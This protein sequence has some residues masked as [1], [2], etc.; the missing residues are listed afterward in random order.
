MANIGYTFAMTM[1]APTSIPAGPGGPVPPPLPRPPRQAGCWIAAVV[2]AVLLLLS[3][4]ANLAMYAGR[5]FD[6]RPGGT[7]GA[8]ADEFPEFEEI[9]SYG[10][11]DVKA[12]RLALTGV[13]SREAAG[14]IWKA[15]L[16]PVEQL[17]LQ[18]RAARQD[19]AVRAIILELDSP[20]GVMT[21]TDEIYQALQDFR[22]SGEGR[23][24]VALVR[25][26]AAS[27]A[28][29]VAMASDWIVAEP[30]AV[31]GSIGVIMQ[32]LNWKELSDKI[33]VRDVTIT[34]GDNKDLLNPFRPVQPEHLAIFQDILDE[35]HD[36]FV[37][38]VQKRL[39]VDPAALDQLTDGR[40]FS[41]QQAAAGGMIDQVGYWDD[42]LAK[43]RELLGAEEVRVVRYEQPR[44]LAGFLARLSYPAPAIRLPA[45]LNER[46]PRIM[47]L[48]TP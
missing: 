6:G 42:A 13:I 45:A 36:R 20:G 39:Q 3:A 2:L 30:T 22:A 29:Y 34:A 1:D 24:V 23:R 41:A 7:G 35:M 25:D 33:G 5:V 26:L 12:V 10:D 15:G 21:P 27:G 4:L 40:V 47:Y 32:T 31:V 28:Y 37:N 19:Q 48:W 9:W 16:D 46:Q 44:G 18:I 14:G 8:A 17:L 38:V 11:G 43:V